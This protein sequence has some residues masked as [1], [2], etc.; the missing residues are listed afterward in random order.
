MGIGKKAEETG[1]RDVPTRSKFGSDSVAVHFNAGEGPAG[2]S[3]RAFPQG[4]PTGSAERIRH[5]VEY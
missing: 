4:L 5:D 2:P 1:Q 3:H